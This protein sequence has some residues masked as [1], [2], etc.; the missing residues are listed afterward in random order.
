[1]RQRNLLPDLIF[2]LSFSEGT[3]RLTAS[4]G[5]TDGKVTLY[6]KVAEMKFSPIFKG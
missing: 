5:L 2:K 3:S 6:G 4:V 1:V